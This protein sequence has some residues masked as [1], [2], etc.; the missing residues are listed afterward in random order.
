MQRYLSTTSYSSKSKLDADN[1]VE[2][3]K[4]AE[5]Q[6][7]IVIKTIYTPTINYQNQTNEIMNLTDNYDLNQ[8]DIKRF[9]MG[10]I[11]KQPTSKTTEKQRLSNVS[12]KLSRSRTK[13]KKEMKI[14]NN[15]YE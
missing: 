15:P 14:S 6:K 3:Q 11:S 13:M 9:K 4:I 10:R 1:R 8:T 12:V 2:R 5:D 7:D